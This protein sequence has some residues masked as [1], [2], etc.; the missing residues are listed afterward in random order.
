M[1][2]LTHNITGFYSAAKGARL[3]YNLTSLKHLDTD[4]GSS[5]LGD[6]DL[7]LLSRLVKNGD[8]QGKYVRYIRWYVE[9]TGSLKWFTQLSTYKHFEQASTSMMHTILKKPLTQ[10]NFYKPINYNTLAYLNMLQHTQ[11]FDLLIYE[12]PQSYLYTRVLDINYQTLRTMLKQR[13]NHR[14]DE[15]SSFLSIVAT[16]PYYNELIAIGLF[17]KEGLWI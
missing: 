3:S 15:W 13:H 10:D 6:K 4:I 2:Y 5:Y 1:Q 12:M 7:K 16:L 8:E 17:E 11:Q 14:L 9:L